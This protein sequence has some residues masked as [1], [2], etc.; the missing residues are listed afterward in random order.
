MAQ[1]DSEPNDPERKHKKDALLVRLKKLQPGCT[2]N[3]RAL[4]K[5]DGTVTLEPM[6]M[7]AELS[8]YWG[9]VFQRPDINLSQLPEW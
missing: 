9:Q 6:Q 7:A 1:D 8:S 2:A 3:L 4:R 5:D